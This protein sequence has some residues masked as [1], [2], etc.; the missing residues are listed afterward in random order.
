MS[1]S[2][3]TSRTVAAA[4]FLF[5]ALLSAHGAGAPEVGRSPWGPTDEIGRLNLMTAESRAAILARVSRSALDSGSA[6]HLESLRAAPESAGELIYRGTVAPLRAP[7]EAPL[8]SYERR[9][10][11][12]AHGFAAAHITQNRDGNV[13]ITE[14]ARFTP[15]YA[16]QRFD[17]VN[18]QLALSGTVELSNGGRH[19]EYR[20]IDNGKPSSASEDVDAPVVSGPSLHGFIKQHWDALANGET[21]AVRMIVLA[22]KTTYGFDIRRAEHVKGRTSFSITPS[23]LFVRLAVAPLRVTFDSALKTRRG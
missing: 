19:L 23:S 15:D 7:A 16:L 22:K 2:K 18:S 14:Q 9:V 12:T 6:A 21:L 20:L 13:I 4:A 5:G 1:T 17:A 3:F 10:A 11:K 8:F